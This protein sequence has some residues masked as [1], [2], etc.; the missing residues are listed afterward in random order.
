VSAGEFNVEIGYQD[1]LIPLNQISVTKISTPGDCETPDEC[2]FV[3]DMDLRIPIPRTPCPQIV[4][5]SFAVNSGYADADCMLGKAN[6]MT[7]TPVIIAGDC[8]TADQCR[9]EVDTEI[10]IPIPRVP[11]PRINLSNFTV[12]TGY[13]GDTCLVD[14]YNYFTI[15]PTVIKGDGCTTPDSCQFDV[16]L[17]LAIPFPKPPCPVIAVNSFKLTTGY[18]ENAAGDSCLTGEN[19]FEITT[20]ITPGDCN[21]PDTCEFA[22]D[23]E[24]VVPIPRPPCPII[25]RKLF[26]VL[27]NEKHTRRSFTYSSSTK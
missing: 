24:L 14:K 9:F 15:T 21:N 7:I 3:I 1:C 8:D 17:A 11:C 12:D 4:V 6:A 25:N 16:E 18:S 19:K 10:S 26:S 5:N 23:L 2:E 20:V 27:S 22:L 13:V